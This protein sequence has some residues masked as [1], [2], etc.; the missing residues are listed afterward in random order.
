MYFSLNLFCREMYHGARWM[1][2]PRFFV[3]MIT[4]SFGQVYIGDF[5]LF[6]DTGIPKTARIKQFF[7][8][9]SHFTLPLTFC[10][11]LLHMIIGRTQV[12]LCEDT[13]TTS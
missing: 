12:C 8:I 5:V 2:D 4:S 6:S 13:T 11:F 3:P 9:I 10:E 7:K 1:N